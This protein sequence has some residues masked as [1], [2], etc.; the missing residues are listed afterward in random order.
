DYLNLHIPRTWQHLSKL[1][2]K[3]DTTLGYRRGSGFING[4]CHP[5]HPHIKEDDEELDL[6]E[7]PLIIMDAAYPTLGF[8]VSKYWGEILR[9]ID[10]VER[11]H[12]VLTINWHNDSLL[13]TRK[14]EQGKMYEKIL[15]EGK[16]RGAWLSNCHE[17]YKWWSINSKQF[18]SEMHVK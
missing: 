4:M 17:I 15:T 3:Y 7:I 16:K 5:F 18:I 14:F 2:F 9:I 12:G 1:G 13:S 8:T 6:L 10:V 11:N